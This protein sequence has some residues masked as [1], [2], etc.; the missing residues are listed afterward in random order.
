MAGTLAAGCGMW[1]SGYLERL[2]R[3]I[4]LRCVQARAQARKSLPD[5]P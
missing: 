5:L 3:K 4:M 2:I 1:V